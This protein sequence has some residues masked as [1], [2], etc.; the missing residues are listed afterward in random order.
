MCVSVCMRAC[1]FMRIDFKRD[2]P[3]MM[4]ILYVYDMLVCIFVC[5]YI[6][7]IETHER[8]HV[9]QEQTILWAMK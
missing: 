6:Y 7:D 3:Q 1:I 9:M 8:G 4:L 2:Y 5:V